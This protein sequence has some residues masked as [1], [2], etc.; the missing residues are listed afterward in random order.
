MSP[1]PDAV[2]A[3]LIV[4]VFYALS[5][6]LKAAPIKARE[7]ME[8]FFHQAMKADFDSC[9]A[10]SLRYEM[11]TKR[12][13]CANRCA[14]G[15]A[16]D[17]R[18]E[19]PVRERLKLN[20]TDADGEFE[21]M[22]NQ[23]MVDIAYDKKN[24]PAKDQ[25]STGFNDQISSGFKG[26][27]SSGFKGQ[28]SSGFK[29][30]RSSMLR[31]QRSS[32][33]GDTM[34]DEFG[35]T[36]YEDC[37]ATDSMMPDNRNIPNSPAN[38]Q[39]IVS[40]IDSIVSTK[41]NTNTTKFHIKDHLNSPN[42]L[43]PKINKSRL[44]NDMTSINSNSYQ[45][46][47]DYTVY[48]AQG[49]TVYDAQGNTVYQRS[50]S[51]SMRSENKSISSNNPKINKSRPTNDMKSMNSNSYQDFSDY[52]VYDA[53]GD[54]VYDEHGQTVYERSLSM[55]IT[56]EDKPTNAI[57]ISKQTV[58]KMYGNVLDTGHK[59]YPH[60]TKL[61]GKIKDHISALNTFHPNKK[62]SVPRNTGTG[63]LKRNAFQEESVFTVYDDQ[64][65]TV[66]DDQLDTMYEYSYYGK[67]AVAPSINV[68]NIDTNINNVQNKQNS[69]NAKDD[70]QSNINKDP[71]SS[72]IKSNIKVNIYPS[73][74][75]DTKKK[76][77][78]ILKTNFKLKN[79]NAD[80]FSD[81]TVYDM[82]GNT[83]YDE[84]GKT[85]Y[86]HSIS[87][88]TKSKDNSTIKPKDINRSSLTTGIEKLESKIKTVKSEKLPK[89]VKDSIKTP[90]NDSKTSEVENKVKVNIYPSAYINTKKI[91]NALTPLKT[92]FM[93]NDNNQDFS[94][95][96]VYDMQGNTM[97]DEQGETM[98]EHSIA[99]PPKSKNINTINSQNKNMKPVN[100][101]IEKLESKTI[102]SKQSS[103]SVK[104]NVKTPENDSKT[105]EV[106][107][108]VKVNI[109]PSAKINTKKTINALTPL[110]TG[111]MKNDNFQDFS[112][113]TV[114]DMQGNTVYDEQGETMYEHSIAPPM[115]S[116]NKNI[117][118][119]Q[120]RNRSSLTTGIKKLDSK[121][122]SV[123]SKKSSKVVKDNIIS[124]ENDSKTSEVE[125]K[126][127]V[128]IYPSANINTKK[129]INALT[130]LKTGF[131]KN[132]NFQDFSDYTV[133]DMQGNTV[134]D[135]QGE[136]MYEHSIAPPPKSKN[137][138]TIN[139]QDKN[140]KPLQNNIEKLESNTKIVNSKKSSKTVKDNVTENDSKT[141]EVENKV[142]INIYPSAK[143]NTKKTNNAL[144]P[145]KTGFMKNDN[146]QDFSDYTVYD[147]QG[148]TVYDEQGETMYEHSIAPPTKSK[149]IN[150]INSQD[151]NIKLLNSDIEKLESKT[152]TV[153]SKKSSKIVKDNIKSTENDSKTSEVDNKIKVNIYPT[154]KKNTN[155]TNKALL[156]PL[157]TGFIKND[158]NQDFSDYTVYD[159]QG[160]TV[161]DEQGET[162]YEHSIAPPPKSTNL[163]ITTSQDKNRSSQG[164]TIN[165][166]SLINLMKAENKKAINTQ[167]INRSSLT[168]GIVKPGSNT[169]FLNSTKSSKV[170][171][172]NIKSTKN[173]SIE[174]LKTSQLNSKIKDHISSLNNNHTQQKK[175]SSHK[176]G[177]DK[178]KRNMFQHESVFTV[179]DDDG[180]TIYDDD[181][182]TM[183]EHSYYE[184]PANKTNPVNVNSISKKADNI[185]A[186]NTPGTTSNRDSP[187]KLQV[188]PTNKKDTK[189]LNNAL[190]PLKTGFMKND[191]FQDFSDYTV[192]D[193]Q[194]NTV[195]DEQGE[196]MYEHSI[197]PPAKSKNKSTI[198]SPDINRS[199][200]TTD[201]EKLDSKT[202]SVKSKK[203]SKVV[204]DNITEHD[205]KTSEVENKVKVNIYPSSKLNTKKTNNALTPLKTG[206]MKND[207]FQ[208]FSDYTVYDMQ[209]NTVYDEQGET[210]YEHSIAPPPKSKNKS[211]IKSPDINRSSLTTGLEKLESKSKKLKSEK[212]SKVVKDNIKYTKKM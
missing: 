6:L 186:G 77:N 61:E 82:Q 145:L 150:T 110:K 38:V 152:K 171:K 83:I 192:Y 23:R 128:N 12:C 75:N 66:Y 195:Y 176:T 51:N 7:S 29:D 204:K 72:K 125:N 147:M 206:F 91:N 15:S 112:D 60:N 13:G 198:K 92:G 115:K 208:D 184:K 122:K 154:N 97:Y 188:N 172:N 151:K 139:S 56:S 104:D 178:L 199:Y 20:R 95:Y 144:T 180:N 69:I 65:N 205:S 86:E 106:E 5:R 165:E 153:K 48:D 183:Y 42:A 52:T 44:K 3:I 119:S 200:L 57:S 197:A 113:Y 173:D 17:A 189:K 156:T 146:N 210:M 74:K 157:K 105:S 24:G 54:T 158:N 41:K 111:F 21:Y 27:V 131:M 31:S 79:T 168:T 9:G 187:N 118:T 159:M 132:D 63:K 28:V 2:F 194:G 140:M 22:M 141:S 107:N 68:D 108:K 19:I 201:I 193:M 14:C 55:S 46:F 67:H 174:S 100:S 10:Q 43:N 101:D 98:Y 149:N 202:K 203:S 177:V 71:N 164:V 84:Q 35:N 191:N 167:D 49:N 58:N 53:A 99:P 90:E 126:V 135:E 45:D 33:E 142:K 124:T 89:G 37:S 109:Y 148:N 190:T 123:K 50:I 73:E 181:E 39:V 185:L 196:T 209:G 18:I 138:N 94:D 160:N 34:F 25:I 155:K 117:T 130:P 30:Q 166:H 88:S 134:Y 96:T 120:D 93:K 161:Y 80:D 143:I 81:Y 78:I 11:M 207:N 64:D 121:T 179:Y 137:I 47:S 133:Y 114:Y 26:Q 87:P 40:G 162:M 8:R 4:L 59:K 175:H 129:T 85:M 170:V 62:H 70:M 103:K 212:S 169:Q 163:N 102:K 182:D 136:T 16:Q 76:K 32:E 127:K 1:T 211:T 116:K 36:M